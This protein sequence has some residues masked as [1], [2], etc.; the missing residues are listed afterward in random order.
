MLPSKRYPQW[1]SRRPPRDL[2]QTTRKRIWNRDRQR[3]QGPYCQD[4]SEGS[5]L[6]KQA[7]IDHITELSRSGTNTDSNLRTLCRR[8]HT[9]R[10]SHAHRGMI[11]AALNRGEIPSD[12]RSLLWE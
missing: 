1:R 7:H 4:K 11:R 3:C 5:L 8:C 12:W 6:L 9:L 2:W 10:I